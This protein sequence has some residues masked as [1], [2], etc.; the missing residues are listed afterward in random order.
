MQLLL[1]VALVVLLIIP[2]HAYSQE[3][4]N[5]VLA[6][7]GF[8]TIQKTVEG[9]SLQ[10]KL[11]IPENGKV[12]FESGQFLL[13]DETHSIKDM[14][15]SLFYNKKFIRLVANSDEAISITASGRLVAS[16]GDDLIYHINGKTSRQSNNEGFSL[17]AV[18]KQNTLQ[19]DGKELGIPGMLPKDVQTQSIDDLTPKQD[20]LILV[21]Q[22]DRVEW[23]NPYKFTVKTFDPEQNPL[24]DFYKTSGY[25]NNI[26]IS[27]VVTNPIGEIIK[28]SSG[29]TQTFGYYEDSVIIPDNARTGT[30]T[31]N[32]TASGKNYAPVT[33]EFQFVVIPAYSGS[34]A[35]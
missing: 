8:G 10:T 2:I 27:V 1:L 18:L 5:F 15:L 17:F 11:Q 6:G 32:V 24:F 14:N 7:S 33:Q 22:Y 29:I 3:S 21:K 25:L 4:Q 13:G 28:T 26:Q 30:Y 16:A 31:L 20:L 34:T 35:S 23:K 19:N 9:A 12:V